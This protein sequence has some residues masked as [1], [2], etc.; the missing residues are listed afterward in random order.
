MC[1]YERTQADY[2]QKLPAGTHSCWGKG[3]THPDPEEKHVLD[4]GVEIPFGKPVKRLQRNETSL[5]YNEYPF[6]LLHLEMIWLNDQWPKLCSFYLSLSLLNVLKHFLII[7]SFNSY[8]GRPPTGNSGNYAFEFYTLET[9]GNSE[10]NWE[11][12]TEFTLASG[13]PSEI[14]TVENNSQK[15]SR[16]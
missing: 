12:F 16:K 8:S 6:I 1:R 14:I 15:S 11:K 13:Q 2:I 10:G 5:L 7:S 3:V 9:P 4:D